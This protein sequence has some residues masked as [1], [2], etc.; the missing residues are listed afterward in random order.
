[1]PYIARLERNHALRSHRHLGRIICGTGF[2]LR[3]RMICCLV[4]FGAIQQKNAWW[5]TS[6]GCN[7][8]KSKGDRR[9]QMS[10][11][12]ASIRALSWLTCRALNVW[13]IMQYAPTYSCRFTVGHMRRMAQQRT[14]QGHCRNKKRILY[15]AS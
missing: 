7:F 12:E 4:C 13:S 14:H 15:K 3:F 1:M 8:L 10:F 6:A 5:P 11:T 9:F 2:N